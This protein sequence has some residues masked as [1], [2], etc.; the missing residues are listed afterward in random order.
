LIHIPDKPEVIEVLNQVIG[1]I[2]L[3]RAEYVT[4][5]LAGRFFHDLIPYEVRKILAAFYTHPNSADLLAGLTIDS[6]NETVTDPACG[7]GTL[8]VSSYQRKLSLFQTTHKDSEIKK[9]HRRFLEKDI[10]GIDIMPFASHI[11]TINLA[12]Q[13]IKQQT[14]LVRIASLN[15]LE[16]SNQLKTTKFTKGKGIKISGF[17]KS[18]QQTLVGT[19]I[20]IKK[21]GSVSMQGKGSEFHL[22]PVDTVIMNPP[23]SD[24]EKMPKEMR[25]KINSNETL[26]K[27]CGKQVNLW[28]LFLALSNLLLKSNGRMGAV[29]P[30][31]IA[32]GKATQDIR[33]FLLK[34]YTAR[35]IIKPASDYAF[36]EGSSFKDILYIAD[37]KKPNVNDFTGIVSIKSSIKNLDNEQ[38][39]KLI[40]DLKQC[41]KNQ[42]N[43]DTADFQVKFVKTQSLLEYSDN[44]M[45]LL[46]FSSYKNKT[47]LNNFLEATFKTAGKKLIKIN[48]E[49]IEEGLHAS[50]AGVSELVFITNPIE[51]SRVERAF[52][53]VE[54]VKRDSIRVRIKDTEMLLDIPKSKVQSALRTVT[55]VKSFNVENIDYVLTQEPDDFQKILELSKFKGK[56]DWVKQR[57]N[58][59]KKESHLVMASRFRTNSIN[60]YHLAFFAP[61]KFV[62]PHT[63]KILKFATPQESL[64]QSLIL[65][66]SLNMATLLNF[67]EQT[68]GAF[69]HIQETELSLF[70]IFN[71]NEL[72]SKEKV[73]LQNVFNK[74]KDKE[75]PSIKE[76][77]LSSSPERRLLD[78]TVLEVLGMEK[79]QI[80]N[81]LDALYPLIAEELQIK[82]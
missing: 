69:L 12:M 13:D 74:L 35:F 55:G 37:K 48:K 27:I 82:E 43:K 8:L 34:N 64:F 59:L 31:N 28:G 73:K 25:D 7:S 66:S 46:G 42:T 56:F 57:K 14:N 63:F 49:I 33:N 70:H 53:I 40:E 54:K 50:P 23:F 11:S 20:L 21:Q 16:L 26:N 81:I 22:T 67:R 52:M 6:W 68:T 45:P 3:L 47:V 15:S 32:R 2:K 30:I 19:Q 51:Q 38:I 76:Q 60:T 36:S 1:A 79:K 4:H 41:Y 39:H 44:L 72:D 24:R 29:I 17:E 5:D 75:F 78:S 65:N 77:Y 71:L 58:V 9:I 18:I 80:D 10:T 61:H 62:A